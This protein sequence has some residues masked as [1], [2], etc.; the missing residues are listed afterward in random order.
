MLLSA[1]KV[2]W[3]GKFH[4][5]ILHCE[6]LIPLVS[7]SRALTAG[8]EAPHSRGALIAY[9]LV[10]LAIQACQAASFVASIFF[11]VSALLIFF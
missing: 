6:G 10:C 2:V 4:F 1:S 7:V 5:H 3:V 8:V 9:F 11:Q